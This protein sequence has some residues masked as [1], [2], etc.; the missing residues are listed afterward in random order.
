[1]ASNAAVER[2]TPLEDLMVAM[3][4]VDTLRHQ[5]GLVERELNTGARRERLLARLRDLYQAQ[6]ID[7]SD[8]VLQEGILAL[9]QERFKYQ[10]VAPNWATRLARIWVT[11]RRWSKPIGFLAV[12]ASLFYGVYFVKDVLPERSLRNALPQQLQT[13]LNAIETLAKNPQIVVQAKQR[14]G[15]ARQALANE[16]YATAK[17]TLADIDAVRKSLQLAYTIRVVSR[18]NENSGIWRAPDINES[19]RNYYLIV[20]AVDANN[21]VLALPILNE[22]SNQRAVKKQWGLRVNEAT[23]YD[24]ARDKQDDGIIQSNK[25]G[26]K[27][28]GYL[29]PEFSIATTGGTITEW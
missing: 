24:I 21:K 12:I 16:D 14:V 23:F 3:D 26:E 18:P 29:Q 5:Q 28:L 7:V 8:A 19:G 2:K 11:R 22:E 6:G 27:K 17:N 10:P 4:V 25:V 20:E 15:L 13:S 9:E 1:M